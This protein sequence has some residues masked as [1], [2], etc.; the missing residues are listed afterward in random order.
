MAALDVMTIR[1][2][3][4][5]TRVLGVVEDL[6]ERLVV[7]IRAVAGWVRCSSCG[8]K[9]RTVHQTTKV[10]VPDLPFGGRPTTLVCGTAGASPALA[11]GP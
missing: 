2:H 9:T 5:A 4:P 3:L 10:A 8:S 7:A 1:L 6:P 11:A